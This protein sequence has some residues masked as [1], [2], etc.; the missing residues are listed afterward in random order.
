MDPEVFNDLPLEDQL[1]YMRIFL[2]Q[3]N[4]SLHEK[5]K[6]PSNI[7]KEDL[8]SFSNIQI[9]NFIKGVQE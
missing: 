1:T 6:N 8:E 2:N 9:N 3:Y 4:Q 7:K 5:N